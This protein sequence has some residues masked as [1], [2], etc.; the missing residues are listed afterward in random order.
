MI[1]AASMDTLSTKFGVPAPIY[2]LDFGRK[3]CNI[4]AMRFPWSD[5]PGIRDRLV[6]L[7]TTPQTPPDIAGLEERTEATA[8][9]LHILATRVDEIAENMEQVFDQF[10]DITLAV[11]EG[12]ERTDRAERRIRQVA[13]RARKKL[14]EGGLEDPALE[15]EVADLHLEHGDGGEPRGVPPMR[16]EMAPPEPETSSVRGVPVETLRRARGF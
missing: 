2:R 11:S 6:A 9:S 1:L 8:E 5:L 3:R 15:G 16:Q 14:A 10:K 7:E 13:Q 12:I 4:R